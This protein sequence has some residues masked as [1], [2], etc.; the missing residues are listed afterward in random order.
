MSF[1]YIDTPIAHRG[2]HSETV[3]ENS[4]E[5]FSLAME[6]GFCI[7]FDLHLSK[8]GIPIVFHDETLERLTGSNGKVANYTLESLKTLFLKNTNQKIP[9]LEEVLEL[10]AG[11]V[12]LI[13]EIK[14]N[15][16]DGVIES[17][18]MKRLI[19]YKGD[20][21]I[22]SF[23]P[24]TL[25]WLREHYPST[26]LGM[27]VTNDFKKSKLSF[28]KKFILRYM[29]FYPVI[30]PEY[31]GLDYESFSLTQYFLIKKLM[32]TKIVFWTINSEKLFLECREFCDNII[33]ENFDPRA[34]ESV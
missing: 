18:V 26:I 9:T 3:P 1:F 8:D 33:F 25:K 7:E 10:V 27:L 30:R 2:L 6:S 34:V 4:L 29:T 24:M 28:F 31:I 11:K 22:Q 20:Y 23:N 15:N 32:L 12:P 19:H 21:T 5:A 17:E 13:I 14:N 16:H